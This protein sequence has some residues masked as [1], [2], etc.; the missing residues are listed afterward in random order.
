LKGSKPALRLVDDSAEPS[1]ERFLC[2]DHIQGEARKAWKQFIEPCYWLGPTDIVKASMLAELIAEWTVHR[3]TMN[4][5]RQ[6]I[7]RHLSTDLFETAKRVKH[8][9]KRRQGGL[10]VLG[11]EKTKASKFFERDDS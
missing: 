5:P 10:K 11:D 2:P 4:V 7:M 6:S 1:Q 8:V 3:A 9:P